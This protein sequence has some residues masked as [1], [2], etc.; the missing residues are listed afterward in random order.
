MRDFE[1]W[2]NDLGLNFSHEDLVGVIFRISRNKSTRIN[3]DEFCEE[4]GAENEIDLK[5]N[6]K[7]APVVK[8]AAHQA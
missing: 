8:T 7:Q 1:N 4:Y 3:F 5:Y 2:F 6:L